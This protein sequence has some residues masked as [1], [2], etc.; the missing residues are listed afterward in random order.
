ML[1]P[2][3]TPNVAPGLLAALATEWGTSVDAARLTAYVAGIAAH[4]A[5]TQRFADE[6]VTPGIRV[7]LTTDPQLAARVIAVGQHVLWCHTFGR[8]G[9]APSGVS[10]GVRYGAN[11]PLAPRV[12]TTIDGMP[13]EMTY[14]EEMQRLTIGTGTIAP[15]TRRV[16]DYEVGGSNVLNR[17][18]GYRKA[19]PGGR[20][21]SELNLV[22]ATSWP[23]SWTT[24]L[25]DLITVLDRLTHLETDQARL[26]AEVMAAPCLSRDALSAKGVAW[27]SESDRKPAVTATHSSVAHTMPMEFPDH[28]A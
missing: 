18:F 21:L 26:L 8:A 6:L 25:L 28:E 24:D 12:T 10:K 1:H 20:R 9:V 16:W 22:H 4:P 7:P 3:S 11:D 14:D 5:F 23:S 13:A 19:H 15:V 2:N 17:W 27:P